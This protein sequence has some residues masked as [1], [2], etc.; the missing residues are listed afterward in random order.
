MK[1]PWMAMAAGICALAVAPS[2]ALA[3]ESGLAAGDA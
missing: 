3:G 2:T 1:R